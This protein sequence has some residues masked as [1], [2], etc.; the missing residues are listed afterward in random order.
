MQTLLDLID[1]FGETKS[2]DNDFIYEMEDYF[3]ANG[4][5][6]WL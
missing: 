4:M 2:F 3:V 1:R 6:L 5:V